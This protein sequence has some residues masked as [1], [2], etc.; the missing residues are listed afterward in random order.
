MDQMDVIRNRSTNIV[1]KERRRPTFS[2]IR[3]HNVQT[4]Q[5][6]LFPFVENKITIDPQQDW[7]FTLYITMLDHETGKYSTETSIDISRDM[8]LAESNVC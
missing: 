1:V 2:N 8:A 5:S 6:T 4:G 3:V 7:Y